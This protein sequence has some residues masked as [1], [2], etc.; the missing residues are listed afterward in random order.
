MQP[1]G[2]PS[3]PGGSANGWNR[4]RDMLAGQQHP[5]KRIRTDEPASYD[6]NGASASSLHEQAPSR[7]ASGTVSSPVFCSCRAQGHKLV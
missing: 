2:R 3:Y 6:S 4:D 7:G 5:S 1:D